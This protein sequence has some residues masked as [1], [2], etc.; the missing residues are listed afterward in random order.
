MQLYVLHRVWIESHTVDPIDP[1]QSE[2]DIFVQAME[3]WIRW[4][5]IRH[6]SRGIHLKIDAASSTAPWLEI[7]ASQITSIQD[8]QALQ[9]RR[10]GTVRAQLPD[11]APFSR[12]GRAALA[13]GATEVLSGGRVEQPPDEETEVQINTSVVSAGQRS[14]PFAGLLELSMT[15]EVRPEDSVSQ[16]GAADQTAATSVSAVQ[17]ASLTSSASSVPAPAPLESIAEETHTT[18][19]WVVTDGGHTATSLDC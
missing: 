9:R 11:L 17:P 8:W 19:S 1:M 5:Q 10:V 4:P 2:A 12:G 14:D 7:D 3:N 6:R 15:A 18:V 16:V 13:D